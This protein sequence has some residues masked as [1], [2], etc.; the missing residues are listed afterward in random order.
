MRMSLLFFMLLFFALSCSKST[1]SKIM[2]NIIDKYNSTRTE[3]PY[4]S[5]V[6]ISEYSKLGDSYLSFNDGVYYFLYYGDNYKLSLGNYA[7]VSDNARKIASKDE[8]VYNTIN[9]TSRYHE[10]KSDKIDPNNISEISDIPID[11]DVYDIIRRLET[12]GPLSKKHYKMF[13]YKVSSTDSVSAI[14]FE[15]LNNNYTSLIGTIYY[16]KLSFCIDSMSLYFNDF[17]NAINDFS[18]SAFD[19]VFERDAAVKSIKMR[20]Y[21]SGIYITRNMKFITSSKKS[22]DLS[23]FNIGLIPYFDNALIIYNDSAFNNYA[24]YF[25]GEYNDIFDSFGGVDK[26]KESFESFN[27]TLFLYKNYQNKND[28]FENN[29]NLADS[30]LRCA[31]DSI[32]GVKRDKYRYNK[33]VS[34]VE[35]KTTDLK[36]INKVVDLGSVKKDTL[37]SA[38]YKI[39]NL[40]KEK[41]YLYDIK[42][43]CDCTSYSLN[44]NGINPQDTLTLTLKYSTK[45]RV[46]KNGST[47]ILRANTEEKLYKISLR[48]DVK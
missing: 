26:V 45:G 17:E 7:L 36:F 40:G 14:Y 37:V 48:L 39:V 35:Y 1:E 13:D 20:S 5:K 25:D 22:V 16:N 24:L 23:K 11:L 15:P 43:D 3:T 9:I 33:A 12:D 10:P 30:T 31:L 18:P 32:Y 47:A 27:N 2:L 38:E 28:D 29:L 6:F 19:I 4:V 21:I 34:T 44:K 8:Y 42:P 41:L 46:G